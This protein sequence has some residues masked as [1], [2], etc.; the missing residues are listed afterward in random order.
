[1]PPAKQ[2]EA[3]LVFGGLSA[4]SLYQFQGKTLPVWPVF[5]SE[6]SDVACD[7]LQSPWHP[8]IMQGLTIVWGAGWIPEDLPGSHIS[9]PPLP[10]FS[11]SGLILD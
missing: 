8:V 1:M 5:S 7:G 10:P 2:K 6:N 4:P 9:Q 3:Q 11:S